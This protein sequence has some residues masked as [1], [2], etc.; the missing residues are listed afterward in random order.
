VIYASFSAAQQNL[1]VVIQNYGRYSNYRIFIKYIGAGNTGQ[2]KQLL[3]IA[4]FEL[5]PAFR[6]IKKPLFPF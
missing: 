3:V 1:P 5:T 6:T 2:P 4:V